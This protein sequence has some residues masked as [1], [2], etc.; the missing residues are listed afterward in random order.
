MKRRG[1]RCCSARSR[2]TTSTFPSKP[3]HEPRTNRLLDPP[4]ERLLSTENRMDGRFSRQDSLMDTE[5][6]HEQRG[7]G[8]RQ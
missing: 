3:R 8:D 5:M 6:L 2:V 4:P 1:T 7:K